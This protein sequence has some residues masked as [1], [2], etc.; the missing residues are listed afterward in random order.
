M[1]KLVKL[2]ETHY[3]V[4]DDSEIKEVPCYNI[5]HRVVVIPTDLE[6]ANENKNNLKVITHSTQPLEPSI[7]S[8]KHD[9]PKEFVLI[10][11]L[12]LS[13]VQ[14]LIYGYSVEKMAEKY[15]D[16]SNDYIVTLNNEI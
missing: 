5:V 16:F 13:E 10:K 1:N 11:P 8:D 9:N 2:S 15:A 7:K 14:E 6:W 3:I 12:S 4:V